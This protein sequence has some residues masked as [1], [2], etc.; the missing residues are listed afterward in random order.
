MKL[1][2]LGANRQ[3]TGSRYCLEVA[4]KRVLIDCGMFQE[5]SFQ[6]R[7][8]DPPMFPPESIAAM[9]L[10]HVH[11]DH[12]GLIPRWVRQGLQSPIYATEP[13]VGLVDIML[14]D[15]AEIQEEDIGYKLKRHQREGRKSPFPY[16]ALFKVQDVDQCGPLF[17][18][19]KYEQAI[20]VT[21]NVTARF[22]DAGHILGS[23]MIE[24]DATENGRATRLVFSGD[25]GQQNKPIVRDPSLL[26]DADY[27]VM[28][29]TYGDRNHP[30]PGDT[31]TQLAEAV[32]DAVARKGNVVIP[33]FAVERA[34]ELVYHFGRL[35][36]AGR[37]P[38]LPIF[39]DSPMAVDVTAVYLK[40]HDYCDEALLKMVR[41]Q[42]APFQYPSL[43]FV[44]TADQ[45]KDINNVQAPCVI[46]ASSGMC[47]AGRIK[48][49]LKHNIEKPEATILFVGHQGEGTLGRQ[50]VDGAKR[51]RIHGQIFQVRAKISQIY[52]FS[53]HADHDG[54]MRWI[55]HFRNAT[56]GVPYSA[57][58]PRRVFL[59]H[60]EEAV[61]LRLAS[62]ISEKL[63]FGTCVPQ[64]RE[65][66]ELV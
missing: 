33:T 49:H 20:Q 32:N 42:Q 9:L 30:H 56:E 3:V 48:H 16:E 39:L 5:R 10:T 22:F 2:F 52:G 62:E 7:N 17:Q 27:I 40:F 37:I 24:I 44:R 66:V 34:Q 12:C 59:T 1:H 41:D 57:K 46:M 65:A 55:S 14:R 31:E 38:P 8:W 21:P 19:V 23:A 36:H 51:V 43:K 58:P 11:I 47:N 15:A 53:G 64:Y 13:S 60:G 18:P 29:S 54:L 45:S 35:L 50:I 25:I 26:S 61:A 63:K 4:G 6:P 28:E